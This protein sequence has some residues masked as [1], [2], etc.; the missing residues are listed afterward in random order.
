MRSEVISYDTHCVHNT[1][2]P[3]HNV[4]IWAFCVVRY[5]VL[6]QTQVG[7]FIFNWP[8]KRHAS[9]DVGIANQFFSCPWS[10]LA[11]GLTTSRSSVLSTWYCMIRTRYMVQLYWSSK[12]VVVSVRSDVRCWGHPHL[13]RAFKNYF[14]SIPF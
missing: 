4:H 2:S 7:I 10:R 12:Y 11:S 6:S 14:L 9:A 1:G 8:I 13:W 3:C 5:P